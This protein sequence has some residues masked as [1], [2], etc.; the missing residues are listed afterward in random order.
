MHVIAR[1]VARLHA[2]CNL[3]ALEV[4]FEDNNFHVVVFADQRIDVLE[5]K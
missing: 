5:R 2:N 3:L 4:D 1:E